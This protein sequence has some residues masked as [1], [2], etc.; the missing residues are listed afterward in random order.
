VWGI[1]TW[2][3]LSGEV[4]LPL[5]RSNPTGELPKKEQITIRT[6]ESLKTSTNCLCMEIYMTLLINVAKCAKY[7][8][9]HEL[10]FF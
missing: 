7:S 10:Q 4:A 3:G 1:Y 2:L 6:G 5:P 8:N 9:S